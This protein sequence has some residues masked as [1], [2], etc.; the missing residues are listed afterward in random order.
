MEKK[1]TVKPNSSSAIKSPKKFTWLDLSF[2]GTVMFFT[3][4]MVN[5]LFA[6][7]GMI[8]AL[9]PFILHRISGR[10]LWCRSYCPRS[11]LFVKAMRKISLG[12]KT[13]KWLHTKQTRNIVLSFF[14]IGLFLMTTTT[15]MVTFG[16]INP[17]LHLRFLI[18]FVLPF[19]LPQLISFSA[20]EA[21]VHASY[22]MYSIM[23]TSTLVGLLLAFLFKPRT[24]CGI[25]PISTLTPPKK[26][27][28]TFDS[29]QIP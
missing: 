10:R 18:V 15:A 14:G 3:L 21:L 6:W 26:S 11:S 25:C 1:I 24:W 28:Q 19:D 2:L 27:A 4:G 5:I 7:V 23:M 9:T 22:R 17:M 29:I 13:P 12:L 8:C 20:P 16:R